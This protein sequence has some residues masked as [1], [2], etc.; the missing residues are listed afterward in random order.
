MLGLLY[1]LRRLMPN[2]FYLFFLYR[3][4]KNKNNIKT[5]LFKLDETII[6]APPLIFPT[7]SK[8]IFNEVF[9]L[10]K[11][12]CNYDRSDTS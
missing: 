12:N 10:T 2:L 11:N 8:F 7:L 1:N 3:K 9:R 6:I 5:F 4:I